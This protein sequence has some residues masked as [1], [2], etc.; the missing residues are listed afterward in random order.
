MN[1][2]LPPFSTELPWTRGSP[3]AVLLYPLLPAISVQGCD[4]P[5]SYLNECEPQPYHTDGHKSIGHLARP[6]K[7]RFPLLYP[8]SR[9]RPPRYSMH[10][11]IC[12]RSA[13]ASA[14]FGL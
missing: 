4:S 3:S 5:T 8:K 2:K 9:R 1:R 10:D 6:P 11:G 13:R 14:A 12:L 7:R